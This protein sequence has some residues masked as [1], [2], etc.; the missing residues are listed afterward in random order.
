[1]SLDEIDYKIIR[2]LMMQGRMTWAELASVLELS[3]PAAGDRVR[4][5]EERNVIQGYAALIDPD[6]IGYPLV[7]FVA[8]TLERP[9]H[10]AAFL[11]LVHQLAEIQ[12]CHHIAGDDDYWLKVR[13]RD[14]KDLERL[15]SDDIKGLAG[16]IKTR[17]TIVLTTAKATPVLPVG[18]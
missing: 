8:V 16:V 17:T 4:R 6:A 12:E 13:C 5:L 7:A 14:T 9:Q 10:R 11:E 15:V 3:A 18:N 2:S 1:M